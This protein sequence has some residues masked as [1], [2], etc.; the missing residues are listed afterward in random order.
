M[1]TTFGSVFSPGTTS[2][3]GISCA[4]VPEVRHHEALGV[5]HH[6]L[7]RGGAQA[8]GV[9]GQNRVLG[10]GV[11]HFG[12]DGLLDVK[13]LGHGFDDE[14]HVRHAARI[15]GVTG[16]AGQH[17]VQGV[18]ILEQSGF[19]KVLGI[20]TNRLHRLLQRG[21]A[22]ADQMH[23]ISGQRELQ[24]D[25]VAHGSRADVRNRL[26]IVHCLNHGDPFFPA[27]RLA[28]VYA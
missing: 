6:R 8:G 23:R 26:D 16:D 17:R 18:A 3:S 11:L 12:P 9:R 27:V 24:R 7:Q 1:S 19:G 5:S 4:G 14:V 2:T 13:V 25:R 22:A 15:V 21:L 28:L 20:R 10:G